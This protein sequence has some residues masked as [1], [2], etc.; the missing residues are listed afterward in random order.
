MNPPR[1]EKGEQMDLQRGSTVHIFIAAIVFYY[2]LYRLAALWVAYID[3]ACGKVVNA[4]T[5]WMYGQAAPT[6][7]GGPILGNGTHEKS[8]SVLPA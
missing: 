5:S 3:P 7:S 2:I 1:N 8:K 6:R 4:V